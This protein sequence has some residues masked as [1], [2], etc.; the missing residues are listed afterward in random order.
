MTTWPGWSDANTLLLPLDDAPPPRTL[1]LG[2]RRFD[3][4]PELHVTL[5][6]PRLGAEL[7]A[8]LGDA[9]EA[10]TRPA[11]EALD[12]SIARSGRAERVEHHGRRDDGRRGTIA[13][14]IE[15]VELPALAHYYRWLETLLGRQLPVPPPHV[16]LYTHGKARG[17]GIPTTRALRAWS[18]GPVDLPVSDAN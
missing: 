13:S 9:L 6:G 7:R 1:D 4:K 11:F 16:T 17:I 14:I 18:K 12:W 15:H 2:A 5:V 8:L 3:P 10:A